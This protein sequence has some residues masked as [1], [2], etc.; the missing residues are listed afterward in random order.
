MD[1][2]IQG[3]ESGSQWHSKLCIGHGHRPKQPPPPPP[4]PPLP[5]L[6][7][8]WLW[9][10]GPPEASRAPRPAGRRLGCA[11]RLR[12]SERGR[13]LAPHVEADRTSDSDHFSPFPFFRCFRRLEAGSGHRDLQ[14]R[15]G[16][17]NVPPGNAPGPSGVHPRASTTWLGRPRRG[18]LRSV[19]PVR[20]AATPLRPSRG[21]EKA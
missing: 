1:K 5:P 6:A 9:R 18:R 11:R 19:G 4:H 7:A 10:R 16:N 14:K 3:L 17:E 15:I 13:D 20:S 21:P 8:P 12:E 2:K